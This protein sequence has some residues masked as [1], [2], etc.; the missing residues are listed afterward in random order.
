MA[1][2]RVV[3]AWYFETRDAWAVEIDDL[4]G[5]V[6]GGQQVVFSLDS[7]TA[8]PFLIYSVEF[9]DHRLERKSYVALMV[10]AAR[11]RE[12]DLFIG[13]TVEITDLP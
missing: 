5:I 9:P 6:K 11:K 13:G 4:E 10:Q 2:V 8:G 12:L 3:Q 7:R 1:R